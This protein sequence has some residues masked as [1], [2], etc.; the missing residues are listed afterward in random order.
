MA[1]IISSYV[2][3]AADESVY[4]SGTVCLIGFFSCLAQPLVLYQEGGKSAI[5]DT[6]SQYDQVH[7]TVWPPTEESLKERLATIKQRETQHTSSLFS[8][9][10]AVEY[11]VHI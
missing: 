3:W 1:N 9:S 6:F 7:H 2:T 8:L 10:A 11:T 4:H 5:I